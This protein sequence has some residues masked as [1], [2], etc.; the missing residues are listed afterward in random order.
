MAYLAR[1][2]ETLEGGD[3]VDGTEEPMLDESGDDMDLLEKEKAEEEE[4]GKDDY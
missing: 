2:D 3:D 1:E 4:T